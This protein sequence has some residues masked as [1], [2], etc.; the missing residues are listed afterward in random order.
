[1]TDLQT[2]TSSPIGAAIKPHNEKAAKMW[3]LG[4]RAYDNI[5]FGVSDALA[6]A[7]QRLNPKAGEQIL[8][9]ATGTGWTA[10]NVARYGARV[11]AV[12]IAPELLAAADELSS[13]VRPP[14]TFRHVD[15]EDL[16]FVDASFDGVIS[17][18]G[19]MFAG[20]QE[21]A[22]RE[23]ARVCR[24]GGRLVLVVWAPEGAIQEFY[25]L[26][27]KYR[28]GPLPSASPLAWGEPDHVR[29][30]LGDAFDLA[31]EPG[32]NDHFVDSVEDAWNW[33]ARGFGPM[34]LL[35]DSLPADQLAAFK[36]EVD[37]YHAS[38]RREAGLHLK[39]EY[40]LIIGR[41]R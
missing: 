3:G 11:T 31:F 41:R 29:T 24:P 7:A 39:R 2:T 28:P 26:I 12:D 27:G 5:S 4:G 19:V 15:A 17:T 14:I 18:F 37:A 13:H 22:A 34:K 23:L 35:I 10:R 20:D 21:Q 9:V 30:L 32:V 1:M 38:Y 16:P 36:Q 33:Y 25:A 40:L 6:Y 8:D